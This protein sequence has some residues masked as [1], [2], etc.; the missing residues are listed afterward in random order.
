MTSSSWCDEAWTT[1][2]RWFDEACT[3][4]SKW[5]DEAWTTLGSW[6]DE[7]WTTPSSRRDE[8]RTTPSSRFDEAQTTPSSRFDEA[9][10]S[11]SSWFDKAMWFTRRAIPASHT[12]WEGSPAG[13][14]LGG[15]LGRGY[16]TGSVRRH[17]SVACR[18]QLD[19]RRQEDREPSMHTSQEVRVV[20]GGKPP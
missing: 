15:E 10:M 18:S 6:F 19:T 1:P 3:T 13:R 14:G 20:A 17:D 4:P 16:R 5:L 9:W 12:P 2:S 7:A 11:P 8:A